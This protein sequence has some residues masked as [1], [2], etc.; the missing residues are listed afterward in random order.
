MRPWLSPYDLYVDPAEAGRAATINGTTAAVPL[1]R[2]STRSPNFFR[3]FY[4]IATPTKGVSEG[5]SIIATSLVAYHQARSI[6]T[7]R[8]TA[9]YVLARSRAS[10]AAA[11]VSIAATASASIRDRNPSPRARRV[12]RR[13]REAAALPRSDAQRRPA[14]HPYPSPPPWSMSG[15]AHPCPMPVHLPSELRNALASRTR[16]PGVGIPQWMPRPT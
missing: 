3:G 9:S 8:S 4:G 12:V 11:I 16:H 13:S 1:K 6:A 5:G 14:A 2:R 7:R 10:L 15:M